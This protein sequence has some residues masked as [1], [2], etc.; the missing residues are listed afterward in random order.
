MII[1]KSKISWLI[2]KN[3]ITAFD[4]LQATSYNVYELTNRQPFD[5]MRMK[6]KNSQPYE[7]NSW[8][9]ILDLAVKQGIKGYGTRLKEE[10]FES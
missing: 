4:R 6:I 1:R 3:S 10:W 9:D 7:Y 2:T 5:V 8:V